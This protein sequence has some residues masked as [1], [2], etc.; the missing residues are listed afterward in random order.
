VRGAVA[1]VLD[2]NGIG[3]PGYAEALAQLIEPSLARARALL[4]GAPRVAA[5]EVQGMASIEGLVPGAPLALHFRADLVERA[6]NGG[7]VLTDYKN[8]RNAIAKGTKPAKRRSELTGSIA[9]GLALQAMTYAHAA[10][11]AS[12]RYLFLGDD[13]GEDEREVSVRADDAE[14][15]AAF[16]GALRVLLAARA[17]G[18]HPPRILSR[19]GAKG[20]PRCG[21]CEV[22]DACVRGDSGAR[23]RLRAWLEEPARGPHGAPGVA[24]PALE[25]ALRELWR[26][27]DA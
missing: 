25:S 11:G 2:E 3:L 23:A 7:A 5:A 19:D 24:D 21:T 10:P 22:R 1:E 26:R 9:K 27:G 8:G 12:G 17:A 18:L 14:L 16:T 15:S 6:G 20:A 4:G 13:V